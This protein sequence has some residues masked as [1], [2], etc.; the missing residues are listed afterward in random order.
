MADFKFNLEKVLDVREKEL[1]L[2]L[3][4]LVEQE[5]KL[6]VFEDHEKLLE[7]ELIEIQEKIVALLHPR[8]N[9]FQYEDSAKSH[10]TAYQ[11]WRYRRK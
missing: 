2:A 7:T 5:K 11:R 3:Q 6:K 9:N 1:K 4:E 8:E 10:P